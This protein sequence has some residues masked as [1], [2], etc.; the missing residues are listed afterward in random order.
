M[1]RLTPRCRLLLNLLAQA[2]WLSTSQIQTAFFP[3]RSAD[4]VRKRLRKLTA[5]K[6]LYRIQPHRMSEAYF[7]LG[8]QGK[9]AL[10]QAGGAEI[11]LERRLPAHLAHLLGI[12]DVRL[13]IERSPCVVKYFFACWEF[14]S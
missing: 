14:A 13:A 7:G 9:S 1:T 8:V 6:I 2:R 5:A 3:G 10:E 4:A 11:V 12:N